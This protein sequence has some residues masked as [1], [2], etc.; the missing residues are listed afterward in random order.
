MMIFCN[1]DLHLFYLVDRKDNV[2]IL[3]VIICLFQFVKS[4]NLHTKAAIAVAADYE[5]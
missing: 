5:F 3:V 1:V 4:L 2:E